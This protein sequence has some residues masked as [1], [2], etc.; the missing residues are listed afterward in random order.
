[1]RLSWSAGSDIETPAALLR[2]NV[3]VGTTAGGADVYSGAIQEGLTTAGASTSIVLNLNATGTYYFAVQTVD[4]AQKKSLWSANGTVVIDADAPVFGGLAMAQDLGTGGAVRLTWSAASDSAPPITY[5]VYYSTGS[6][7]YNFASADFSTTGVLLDV[8]GL[9]NNMAHSFTV[10]AMD[11][12]GNEDSNNIARIITPTLASSVTPNPPDTVAA[13]STTALVTVTWVAPVQNT[14]GSDLTDLAGFHIFR[15]SSCYGTDS[16]Q[17]DTS[18]IVAETL[19]YSDDTV[20]ENELYYYFLTAENESGT[21]SASSTCAAAVTAPQAVLGT[22]TRRDMSGGTVAGTGYPKVA[23][24]GLTMYLMSGQTQIA[25]AVTGADGSFALAVTGNPTGATFTLQAVITEE[26]GYLYDDGTMNSGTAVRTLVKDVTISPGAFKTVTVA[27]LGHGPTAGDINCDW[28]VNIT[29]MVLLKPAYG[30]AL[31]E[32]GYNVNADINGDQIVD[33]SDF[34]LL[35]PN[36]GL[37]GSP[38][39]PSPCSP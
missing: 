27:P 37:P 10:R 1:V 20:S 25:S 32:D 12:L 2:Y 4:S 31:G 3:R 36:F 28:V 38:V 6:R 18:L 9:Q 16:V 21:L 33:I 15:G 22:V 14:N 19:S 29:D 17:L 24:P 30:K 5:N 35:K 23:V 7:P 11:S 13:S 8:S 39:N 26:S 34:V